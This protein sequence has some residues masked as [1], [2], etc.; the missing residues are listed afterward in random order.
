MPGSR[1]LPGDITVALKNIPF[2]DLEAPCGEGLRGGEI[3]RRYLP[4]GH[5]S[6]TEAAI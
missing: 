1:A 2:I 4:H 6:Y 5:W 3:V